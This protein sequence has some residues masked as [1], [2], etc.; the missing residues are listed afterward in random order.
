[1]KFIFTILEPQYVT[2]HN[3]KERLKGLSETFMKK[4]HTFRRHPHGR[5]HHVNQM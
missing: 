4:R 1:V 2:M 5:I 3:C